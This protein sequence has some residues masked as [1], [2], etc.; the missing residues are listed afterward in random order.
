VHAQADLQAV[1]VQGRA[2]IIAQVRPGAVE[3]AADAGAREA[4]RA[5]LAAAMS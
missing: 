2:G 1:G 3:V 5:V 4:N